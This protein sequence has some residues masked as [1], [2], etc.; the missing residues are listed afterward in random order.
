MS[1][2][3]PRRALANPLVYLALGVATPLA[4]QA[5]LT[6][7]Q[8]V[9]LAQQR[10]YSA[11]AALAARDAARYRYRA[12]RSGLLPQLSLSS[13]L[14]SYNRSIVPV[15]QPD[16]S[17]LF[18]TQQQ[19]SASLAMQLSQEIPFTGGELF[20][21][22]S[23]RRLSVSGVEDA[24]TWSSTPFA[25]GLRQEILRP[26]RVG[27]DRRVQQTGWELAERQYRQ[28]REAIAL[29]TADLFFAVYAAEVAL[30]N[31]IANATTND[32]LYLLNRGRFDVGRIG[33]NDLLQS[34]LALL[35]AQTAVDEARLDRARAL[36]AL[37]LA[38]R[39]PSGTAVTIVAPT[40]IPEFPVDTAQSVAE[41]LR[42]APEVSGA[43]LEAVEADRRVTEAKL[44]NGIGAT[45][46]AT[47]G[48]NASAPEMKL[49]YQDLLEARQ[50]T[51]QVEVPVWQW[52]ARTEGVQAAEAE[53]DQTA[54]LSALALEQKAQEAHFAALRLAQARRNL[55][56]S[57]KADTVGNKRFEVAYNRYV[58]GRISIDNLYIAQNEK[59][60]ARAQYV[61]ALRGY[62]R[63][64]YDLRRVTLFD[65][66]RN[67]PI[68]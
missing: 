62:W 8:A 28:D 39:I 16:G 43:D 47:F 36:A 61:E 56:L 67:E 38:L 45:V 9:I 51:V 57:A 19:T 1:L 12:F 64:Y 37:R 14:P 21:T 34:E 68:R 55:L 42:Y 15:V 30:A 65:F 33:E 59:D 4:A 23:L 22:S 52:G 7:P 48:Y 66:E 40:A 5:P 11:E 50:L 6:L 32:T 49:A 17:T 31:A 2:P 63:A 41:A 58:I 25:I 20:M 27:W 35:R 29:Q 10:G 44:D 53:R 18:R 3:Q 54:S 60:Q 26:N 24:Q 13:T 46:Q